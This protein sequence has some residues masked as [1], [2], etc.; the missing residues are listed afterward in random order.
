MLLVEHKLQSIINYSQIKKK[1]MAKEMSL[2]VGVNFELLKT[3]LAAMYE[4]GKS[5]SQIL[6]L[7]TKVDSPATVS[8]GEMIDEFKKAFGM[9]EKSAKQIEDSLKSVTEE[10]ENTKSNFD[11]E[12]IRF[13]LQAAFVYRKAPKEGDAET[14]YAFAI[15]VDLGEALPDMGFLKL[16]SLSIAVWNTERSAILRQ[17][18]TGNITN[19]LKELDTKENVKALEA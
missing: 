18:G 1:I 7:P 2:A 11:P 10:G 15:K 5:E 4:K 19:L 3:E 16:N 12:K 9:D 14:E 6:L 17:M 8:L 13:Q